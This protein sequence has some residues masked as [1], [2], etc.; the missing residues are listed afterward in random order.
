MT[1]LQ[2]RNAALAVD[3]E[4]GETVSLKIGGKE[5]IAH[6][7]P[8]FTLR[9]RDRDGKPTVLDAR[10]AVMTAFAEEG[11]I[12][13]LPGRVTVK[14]SL[15]VGDGFEWRISIENHSDQLVE[16]VDFVNVS[17]T[18]LAR[19]GGDAKMLYPFNEGA[20]ID[21][22]HQRQAAFPSR[23]PEYPSLGGYPMFPYMVQSQ[24]LC[25][26]AENGSLYLG[27]HDTHRAPKGIDF[28]PEKDPDGKD[29]ETVGIRFR[30][31]CG[32]GYGE[33][34]EPDY[35]IVWKSFNG[36]WQDGAAIY[37][38]WFE[39]NLPA[40]AKKIADNQNL[41]EWYGDSPLIVS[42]PVR[43]IHDMDKMEPNALFPYVSALPVIDEIAEKTHSRILVLLMHWE[44]TA[45]WAPP[46]VW[47]PFG[48][49]ECFNEF[50]NALHERGDLLGVYCSG[51]GWTLKSN[52]I[53]DYHNEE[54]YEK[55]GL[56][57]AMCVS[58]ENEVN[59]SRI[60]TAQRAGYDLCVKSEK[61]GKILDDAYR[62][63]LQSDVDYVQ[64]LDQNHGG[65]QYFCYAR[66]HGHPP[67]PGPWMTESMQDLLA[68][69][70]QI[71][72]KTL[73]GCESACAEPYVG[74]LL[75]SDNRY[76]LNWLIGEPVPAYSF[77]YHEY[78]RN[79]MGN[80]VSCGLT[81][82]EDTLR[83]R[84]AYSFAAGDCMTVVLLPD[85]RFLANWGGR[86]FE[87]LPDRELALT[88][89]AHMQ[90]FYDEKAKPFLSHGRMIPAIPYEGETVIFHSTAGR[91]I[92]CQKVL[93]TAWEADG[94]R[95]QIF[96]NH[97]T[98]DVTITFSGRTLIVPALGGELVELD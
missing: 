63:L 95:A 91:E 11:G 96:V 52:L 59:L 89:A 90:T 74:N 6:R 54:T 3:F 38:D 58:P 92:V 30:L 64:I 31:C 22:I 76:E 65:S 45:P 33:N 15:T 75:F 5:R 47:P 79:F 82:L 84:M 2:Y 83:L 8:L 49:E 9:L 77:V 98:E 23:D 10:D 43:G 71:A 28:Y 94:R 25:C 42:Y 81:Q 24:F 26:L 93:S 27:V 88:F 35:P 1:E 72:G 19:N 37:R 20:L 80:Q 4:T 7:A 87:H 61:A 97:T 66:D 68:G 12:Y 46:Y 14:V 40:G 56:S 50:M 69:W 67:A 60:C 73:L 62:P 48:G 36:D 34:W 55:D 16:W 21:D 39:A 57:A 78:L 85:G 51:F 18:P 53:A 41:P 13:Q 86:D 17:L 29:G 32:V 44:G 70:N